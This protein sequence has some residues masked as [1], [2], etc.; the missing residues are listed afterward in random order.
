MKESRLQVI[1]EQIQE[2]LVFNMDEI[3]HQEWAGRKTKICVVPAYHAS[4]YVFV[5]VPRTGTR[6]ALS[7][8]IT[9]DGSFLRPNGFVH[10]DIFK[11]WFCDTFNV[12]LA[13]HREVSWTIVESH[14]LHS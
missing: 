13:G 5:P 14:P 6:I 7:R 1:S 12:E 11:F 10:S 3:G 9:P 8:C 4:G 2:F